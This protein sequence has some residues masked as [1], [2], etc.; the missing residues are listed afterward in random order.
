MKEGGTFFQYPA[1]ARGHASPFEATHV[2]AIMH[3]ANAQ[4]PAF[5]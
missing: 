2:R 5:A 1:F 4:V 3:E